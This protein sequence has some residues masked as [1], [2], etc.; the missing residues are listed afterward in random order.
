MLC[1]IFLFGSCASNKPSW[2][3]KSLLDSLS[4]KNNPKVTQ[5]DHTFL[6]L[7]LSGMILFTLHTF[8]TR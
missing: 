3:R 2:E 8:T 6:G 1:S 7:L 4:V 5:N